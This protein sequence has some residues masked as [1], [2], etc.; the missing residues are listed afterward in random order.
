MASYVYIMTNSTKRVLY[1][2][3][4]SDLR[5]RVAQHKEGKT[6]SFTQR[7]KVSKL[8][9]FERFDDVRYAILRE[10]QIKAGSRAK[11]LALIEEANPEWID[12]AYEDW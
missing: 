8:V 2:G 9:Y 5:R 1:T 7:Y 6:G 3:V 12:L 10:K 4:T 11:K